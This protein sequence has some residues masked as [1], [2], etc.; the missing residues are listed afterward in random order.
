MEPLT[1]AGAAAYSAF[2]SILPDLPTTQVPVFG[3]VTK[4]H[5]MKVAKYDEVK[6]LIMPGDGFWFGGHMPHSWLI[7]I[8]YASAVSHGG[9]FD[10]GDYDGGGRFTRDIDGP[11]WIRDVVEEHGGQAVLLEEE[12]L[13]NAR[14]HKW[15][16]GTFYWGPVDRMRFY[17]YDGAAAMDEAE[18]YRGKPYGRMAILYASMFHLPFLREIAFWRCR[19]S[20]NE[21]W[22][23]FA[24][25]CS[26][27]Q[28]MW[29]I[30]GGVDCVPGRAVQ[31]TA[32]Q[33][34]WQSLLWPEKVVIEL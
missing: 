23:D 26:G 21:S 12:L 28:K 30:V 8:A 9:N 7:R 16:R 32:P 24:P 20:L 17:D 33:D 27:A 4:S 6:H 22:K 11:V 14:Y 5:T 25:F 13:R 29:S 15:R 2:Q 10:R 18:R 1:S 19:K 31:M 3:D 34:T